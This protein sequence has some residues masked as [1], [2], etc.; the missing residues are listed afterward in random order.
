MMDNFSQILRRMLMAMDAPSMRGHFGGAIPFKIQ[1]NFEIPLFEGNIDAYALD[2]WL[3]LLESY[4][5]INFFYDTKN[6]TFTLLKS[7]PHI[8]S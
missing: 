1:V 4:F 7:L 6:I 8:K 2:K 5:F 3:I